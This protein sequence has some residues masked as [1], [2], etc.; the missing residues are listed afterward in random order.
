ML[1]S[2]RHIR[3]E[4]LMSDLAELTDFLKLH[5]VPGLGPRLTKAL[6]ERFGTVHSVLMA[7]PD[8]LR[9][10][11]HIGEKL[12]GDLYRSMREIDVSSE[13]EL[14]KKHG[15]QLLAAGTPGY[16]PPLLEIPDAPPLLY[17][18][19][20]WNAS[21]ANAIAIVGSRRCTAY[22]LRIAERLAGGLAR[23]G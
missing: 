12:A 2:T 1:S 3:G 23:A 7:R 19:G 11:P 10:V 15:T 17:I 9:Q 22:G 18:R 21:D 13:L 14:L 16:P 6:L 8:Q 4:R 20:G 5:L